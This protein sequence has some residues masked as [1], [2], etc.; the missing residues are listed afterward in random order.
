MDKFEKGAC[1]RMSKEGLV[2]HIMG[3]DEDKQLFTV[4][5]VPIWRTDITTTAPYNCFYCLIDKRW[6]T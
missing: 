4:C 3:A 1:V 6:R 2:H 5:R